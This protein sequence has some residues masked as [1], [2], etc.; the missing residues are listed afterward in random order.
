MTAPS[1]RAVPDDPLAAAAALG[2]DIAMAAPSAEQGRRISPE[3]LASLRDAGLF[4]IWLPR[5]VGGSATDLPTILAVFEEIARHDGSTGWVAMIGSGTN[6]LLSALPPDIVH[7]VLSPDPDIPTG[8]FLAPRGR[9]TPV[10]GGYRV[11]GRWSFGSGCEHC[12]WLIGG[13]VVNDGRDPLLDEQGR[14][15]P[16]PG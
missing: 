1:V 2:P 11:S 15:G 6:L 9:A 4:R 8:G 16:S 12:D 13:C 14:P 10:E 3:L 5:E 7:E